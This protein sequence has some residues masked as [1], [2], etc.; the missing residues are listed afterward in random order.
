M[1]KLIWETIAFIAGF[2]CIGCYNL[3]SSKKAKGEGWRYNL[4][5]LFVGTTY[6]LYAIYMEAHAMKILQVFFIAISLKAI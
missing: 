2:I 5:M 4:A 1:E 6:F 3:V